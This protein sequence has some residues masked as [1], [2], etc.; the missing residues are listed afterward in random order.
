MNK[1]TKQDI[2]EFLKYEWFNKL[3]NYS[4]IFNEVKLY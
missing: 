1:C 2:N 4:L 3:A